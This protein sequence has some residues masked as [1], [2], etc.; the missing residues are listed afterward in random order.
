MTSRTDERADPWAGQAAKRITVLGW[1]L[2][3]SLAVSAE[4]A[5]VLWLRDAWTAAPTIA[6]PHPLLPV[7]ASERIDQ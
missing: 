6:S 1:V 7:A 5:W 4:C 2:V 3:L